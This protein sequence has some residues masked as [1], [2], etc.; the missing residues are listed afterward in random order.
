MNYS[1]GNLIISSWRGIP[2][3]LH[4]SLLVWCMLAFIVG[5]GVIGGLLMVP[6]LILLMAI[7]EYG[8]AL[9]ARARG[10][11]VHSIRLYLFH[12]VCIHELPYSEFEEI[13][14]AWGGVLAQLLALTL[15]IPL[16]YLSSEFLVLNNVVL[17]T[18]FLVF[19]NI[20]VL[21]IGLN[22][23]PFRGLD[24]RIAWKILPLAFQSLRSRVQPQSQKI[25]R[26]MDWRQQQAAK[27]K[28]KAIAD[29]LIQRLK[30]KS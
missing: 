23:L 24:G 28:S 27:R 18:L 2:V 30:N 6:L 11:A 10:T 22:L 9:V 17:N 25:L 13:Q 26:S 8:H 1:Q 16:Y 7:H 5:G 29:D 3:Y 15:V 20:N 19:V 21:T 12:G 14:I 4:W